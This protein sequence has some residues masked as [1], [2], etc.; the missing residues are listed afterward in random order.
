MY[1]RVSGKR[2]A[3]S[4]KYTELKTIILILLFTSISF[5][6]T[7]TIK[8]VEKDLELSY[9]KILSNRFKTDTID[10]NS[11]ELNNKVFKEK[12]TNYI[13]TYPKTLNYEFN[14][15]KK[16]IHIVTSE[17]K[18]FRIYSWNTWMGGTMEDFENIFQY[19]SNEKVYYKNSLDKNNGE[20][21]YVPFYSQIYTLKVNRKTYYL[22][23][24]NG[25]YSSK[26]ASQSIQIFNIENNKLNDSVK[27]IKTKNGLTNSIDFDFDFFSVVNRHERPL[28]LIKYDT[29]KRIIYIPIVYENGKVTNNYMTYEFTGKYFEKVEKQK[30]T[31]KKK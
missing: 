3:E 31:Y 18:L 24:K 2:S 15:L 14:L 13:K 8:E 21:D 12:I 25:S 16:N 29:E 20:W 11:L 28:E 7:I 5:S 26:D 10:S 19:K 27:L 6:Q 1:L 30:K 9:K 22:V 23:I 17:D 4:I